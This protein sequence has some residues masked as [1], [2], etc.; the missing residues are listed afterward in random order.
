[1]LWRGPKHP[2]NTPSVHA[3]QQPVTSGEQ[4]Q[5]REDANSPGSQGGCDYINE[6]QQ[7][8]DYK[9]PDQKQG[10]DQGREPHKDPHPLA[11]DYGP[12]YQGDGIQRRGSV[13][14][15]SLVDRPGHPEQPQTVDRCSQYRNEGGYFRKACH[16]LSPTRDPSP[17]RTLYPARAVAGYEDHGV[18]GAVEPNVAPYM[19]GP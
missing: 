18:Y 14:L 9:P 10:G 8:K 7:R 19:V 11:G 1:M 3:T 15:P 4:R 16:L 6:A 17:H 13:V 12:R 5:Q 2:L